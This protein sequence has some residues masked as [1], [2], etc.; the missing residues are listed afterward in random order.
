MHR[1]AGLRQQPI[2][3]LAVLGFRWQ[4][5]AGQ[6]SISF[7]SPILGAQRCD[8]LRRLAAVR[9]PGYRSL[10]N[11]QRPAMA[12]VLVVTLLVALPLTL[13]LSALIAWRYRAAV[14]QL[15]LLAPS[16]S[17][18]DTQ[19]A[20]SLQL[21]AVA[22]MPPAL[23]V[24]LPAAL[25]LRQRQLN[26]ALAL[27]SVLIGG[28]GAWLFLLVHQRQFGGITP[29]L[30]LLVGLVWCSPGLVLQAL[31][32][33]WSL[34]RQ[35][36]VLLGWGS[37]LVLL[38]AL[39]SGGFR[40]D[41]LGLVLLFLVPAL[42]VLGLLFGVPGLRAIAPYLY[43][44]VAPLCLAVIAAFNA[45]AALVEQGSASIRFVVASNGAVGLILLVALVAVLGASQPAHRLAQW[46]GRLYRR[47]A[48]SDLSYLF[49]ASWLLVLTLEL[50][51]GFNAGGGGLAPLLPLLA[52]LWV[53][54]LFRWLP[55][56]LP[57]PPPGSRPPC[58]LVLR[59]FRRGGPMAWLFDHVV[60][61]WRLCGPV[62]LITAADLAS[63]TLEP[64][65]L[66]AFVEGR[67]QDRYIS[68][69]D[70]LHTQLAQVREH[71]DHDGRWRVH[72]FCC[73]ANSWKPTLDALLSRSDAVLMDLR[74]FS[75]RNA[76]CC[77]E[78]QRIGQSRHLGSAVLVVDR[79]TDRVAAQQALGDQPTA[80]I[81]WQPAEHRLI[82]ARDAVLAPLLRP[83]L[84]P[85]S[86]P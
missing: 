11:L 71:P 53:P 9:S 5:S 13:A 17:D 29:L 25:P 57:P 55:G 54:V 2:D 66:V 48:F 16:P 62:L 15:M 32:L 30:L 49:A 83:F 28:T 42:L 40:S 24:R 72:E 6:E 41:S 64:H 7:M 68:S 4:G 14:R 86:Q 77:H 85:S 81:T 56:W 23:P 22:V 39:N 38:L 60:Q 36:P 10:V 35:L 59:V 18:S 31:V 78:L 82:A 1:P 3:P 34:Q 26:L 61:R 67:L 27:V 58:L 84:S 69:A 44:V 51:P 70:Q 46:L 20:P 19:D 80:A 75:S 33:R 65:E 21:G 8:A 37:G 12:V 74:G 73:Y 47:Q 45:L 63:R 79:H 52:W 43:P 50:L 76:G